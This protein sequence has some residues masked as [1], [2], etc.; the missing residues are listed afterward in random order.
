MVSPSGGLEL[1]HSETDTAPE[2]SVSFPAGRIIPD[3]KLD[4]KFVEVRFVGGAFVR[5]HW[6]D[7]RAGVESIGYELT[8]MPSGT[9]PAVDSWKVDADSPNPSFYR[10][11][12]STWIPA[13]PSHFALHHHFI[14]DG[15][16][17]CIEIVA[18]QFTWREWNWPIG[19]TLTSALA[20]DPIATG[21]SIS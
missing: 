4:Q 2:C 7:D 8:Q 3:G 21:A 1:R 19:T 6:H 13:L 20:V 16:D 17:T 14:I 10:V 18:E 9:W 11:L 5:V 12:D 15:R